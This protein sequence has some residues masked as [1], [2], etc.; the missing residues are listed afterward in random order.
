MATKRNTNRRPAKA[1][2]H[3]TMYPGVPFC[4]ACFAH[5]GG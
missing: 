2:F 5:H 4:E 1:A 3:R